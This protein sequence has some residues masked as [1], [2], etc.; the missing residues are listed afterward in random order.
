[1]ADT[2]TD[3]DTCAKCGAALV[4]SMAKNTGYCRSH[5]DE[6]NMTL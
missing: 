2:D 1:M 4:S 5:R 3:T 6:G